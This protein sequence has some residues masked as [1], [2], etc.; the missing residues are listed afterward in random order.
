[1]YDYKLIYHFSI[2]SK[3]KSKLYVSVS[4]QNDK[5]KY[6]LPI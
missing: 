3:H 1:M 4:E 6:W 5:C 2:Y